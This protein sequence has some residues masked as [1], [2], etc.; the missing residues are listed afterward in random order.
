MITLNIV[1]SG[2]KEADC[3]VDPAS[4]AWER[5]VTSHLDVDPFGLYLTLGQEEVVDLSY[6]T[7][8]DQCLRLRCPLKPTYCR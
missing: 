2:A 5:P 7:K 8:A 4:P 6:V 1:S 3:L